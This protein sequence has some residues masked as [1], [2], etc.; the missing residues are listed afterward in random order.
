MSAH[1]DEKRNHKRYIVDGLSGSMLSQ[2]VSIANISFDG[3]QVKTSKRLSPGRQYNL[4]VKH[5]DVSIM[6][7]GEVAWSTLSGSLL[8]E[9]GQQ[10]PVYTAGIKFKD[11]VDQKNEALRKFIENSRQTKKD[12]RLSGARCTLTGEHTAEIEVEYKIKKV[13]K[14]GMQVETDE[15]LD[16]ESKVHTEL[17]LGNQT[18]QAQCRVVNCNKSEENA[19]KVLIGLEFLELSIESKE[20]LE[21]FINEREE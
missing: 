2:D 11:N 3:I 19:G 8:M 18:I 15:A 6:I 4:K 14:S 9:D 1:N 20:C 21:R 12:R 10:A 16:E 7:K 17:K 13:S 5:E